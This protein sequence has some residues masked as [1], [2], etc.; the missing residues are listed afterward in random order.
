L[1]SFIDYSLIGVRLSTPYKVGFILNALNCKLFSTVGLTV[2]LYGPPTLFPL[3]SSNNDS[4]DDKQESKE[5]DYDEDKD[6]LEE[7]QE[8][9]T[10][11][12]TGTTINQVF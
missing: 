7:K 1:L 2:P 9:E 3:E 5:P 10:G 4:A 6:Q 11:E 12:I 8:E